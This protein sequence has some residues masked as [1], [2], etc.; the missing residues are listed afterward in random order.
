MFT[1]VL[2]LTPQNNRPISVYFVGNW[3]LETGEFLY[4]Q[5]GEA[6]GK[7]VMK[8]QL[9]SGCLRPTRDK[10]CHYALKTGQFETGRARV[11]VR[12]V[13][14]RDE[15]FSLTGRKD[16]CFVLLRPSSPRWACLLSEGCTQPASLNANVTKTTLT[17]SRWCDLVHSEGDTQNWP[18]QPPSAVP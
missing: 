16:G 14:L 17:L 13:T 7:L 12:A 18:P 10:C 3:L 5:A 9:D 2:V 8:L 6:S 15:A 1:P 11:L 4:L